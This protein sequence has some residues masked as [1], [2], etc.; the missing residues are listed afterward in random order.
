VKWFNS[1]TNGQRYDYVANLC[2]LYYSTHPCQPELKALAKFLTTSPAQPIAR[3]FY[4]FTRQLV[5]KLKDAKASDLAE[6]IHKGWYRWY[7]RIDDNVAKTLM[8][9]YM[10]PSSD[11]AKVEPY[12]NVGS[13]EQLDQYVQTFIRGVRDLHLTIVDGIGTIAYWSQFVG[14]QATLK[15]GLNL[16]AGL[17]KSGNRHLYSCYAS[18]MPNEW[19]D[20]L[21]FPH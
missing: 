20:S 11:W 13:R 1:L 4:I 17:A 2:A 12:L 21:T 14:E 18:R 16:V 15:L 10:E 19:W 8:D 3:Y 7:I 5:V 6:Y 9:G